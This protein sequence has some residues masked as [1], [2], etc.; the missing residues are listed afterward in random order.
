MFPRLVKA[1]IH[2]HSESSSFSPFYQGDIPVRSG[3][4]CGRQSTIYEHVSTRSLGKV[5]LG[6]RGAMDH[7]GKESELSRPFFPF[8]AQ[9]ETSS[10]APLSSFSFRFSSF[11]NYCLAAISGG[12]NRIEGEEKRGDFLYPLTHR[13]PGEKGDGTVSCA[14]VNLKFFKHSFW[15][16]RPSTYRSYKTKTFYTSALAPVQ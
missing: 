15:S 16:F 12:K 2:V 13:W 11:F 5:P 10:S 8:F 7:G 1:F 6:R 4:C 14:H 9:R 3:C